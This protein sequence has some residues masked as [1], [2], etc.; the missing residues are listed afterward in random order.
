MWLLLGGKTLSSPITILQFSVHLLLHPPPPPL[1]HHLQYPNAYILSHTPLRSHH[2]PY[3]RSQL[4]HLEPHSP[5]KHSP[6]GQKFFT[7]IFFLS[8]NYGVIVFI[9][10]IFLHNII[11]LYTP[12][13][14]Q[15]NPLIP[16]EISHDYPANSSYDRK[17]NENNLFA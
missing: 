3:C 7:I 12:I 8:P 5:K 9:F 10:T 14:M 11:Y 2:F 15:Q 4:I 1:S 16:K 13:S 17:D 6:L